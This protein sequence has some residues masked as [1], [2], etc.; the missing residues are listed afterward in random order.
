MF[1]RKVH[2]ESTTTAEKLDKPSKNE[3]RNNLMYDG[4]DNLGGAENVA[5]MPKRRV[6]KET[7]RRL[8]SQSNMHQFTISAGDFN[9][10]RECWIKSDADCK[11][12]HFV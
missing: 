9:G 11:S 6:S 7:I 2:P 12:C 5:L 3:I 8:K 4:A 10:N 1:H